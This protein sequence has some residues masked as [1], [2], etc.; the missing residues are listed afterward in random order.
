MGILD[1]TR[2]SF[3]GALGLNLPTGVWELFDIIIMS[4]AIGYIFQAFF[5][6]HVADA[7]YDPLKAIK[8]D[9]SLKYSIL[10][11]APA[12]IFHELAHKFVA[13]SFGIP[14][15]FYASYG[16]LIIGVLLKLFGSPFLFFVP[17]FVVHPAAPPLL[18]ALIAVVGPLT[19]LLI[20][21]ICVYLIK[22][23]Q[24]YNIS[25]KWIMILGFTRKINIFLF[26]FNMLPI[27]PFDGYQFFS[28]LFKAF[29]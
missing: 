13:L 29:F 10:A 4:L 8:R 22:N 7:K 20:W 18:S 28:G 19:N 17:G 16:F 23:H 14:A 3:I 1:F 5:R 9:S 15:T 21:G 2:E 26:F 25:N 24:K 6:P 11:V 27:P 12:V